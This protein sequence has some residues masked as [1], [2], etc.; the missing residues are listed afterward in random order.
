MP[1]LYLLWVSL[2]WFEGVRVN[3]DFF[4]LVVFSFHNCSLVN[5]FIKTILQNSFLLVCRLDKDMFL[6][7]FNFDFKLSFIL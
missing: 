7:S 5:I 2:F 3:T 6:Q 4:Y 1:Y